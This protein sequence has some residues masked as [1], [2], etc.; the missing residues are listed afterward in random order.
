M[1]LNQIT[2]DQDKKKPRN[3]RT[4][5]HPSALKDHAQSFF[6]RAAAYSAVSSL[7]LNLWRFD[8]DT[9]F[10]LGERQEL[11]PLTYKPFGPFGIDAIVTFEPT[12]PRNGLGF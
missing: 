7:C 1:T 9:R 6:P 2:K 4:L 3:T 11:L 5:G 8:L 10:G 12:L